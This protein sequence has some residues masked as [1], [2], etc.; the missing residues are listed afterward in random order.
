MCSASKC[1]F[2]LPPSNIAWS[3]LCCKLCVMSTV[4]AFMHACMF[5]HF[6]FCPRH[7][8]SQ[9][10][11]IMFVC[12]LFTTFFPLCLFRFSSLFL[13]FSLCWPL[14]PLPPSLSLH[15]CL[16][17]LHSISVTVWFSC[18]SIL[19]RFLFN[20]LIILL[21]QPVYI[22][23]SPSSS[24]SFSLKSVTYLQHSCLMNNGGETVTISVSIS[25]IPPLISAPLPFSPAFP[26][27][28]LLTSF[29]LSTSLLC[30]S[31]SWQFYKIG[32]TK[33]TNKITNKNGDFSLTGQLW[34]TVFWYL[35][36]MNIVF[37]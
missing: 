3:F 35:T 29:L 18:L 19:F 5:I 16:S 32:D 12:L 23:V 14:C 28:L 7:T 31:F 33:F 10:C 24:L 22:P 20:S 27:N 36:F 8:E 2:V 11:Q 13:H 21:F 34:N 26:P 9:C 6:P 37:L 30:F 15:T 1:E 17:P 25:R 4:N